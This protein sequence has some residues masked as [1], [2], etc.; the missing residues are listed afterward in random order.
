MQY[1]SSVTITAP[2]SSLILHHSTKS[3]VQILIEVSNRKKVVKGK[4]HSCLSSQA[5]HLFSTFP[6]HMQ[7]CLDVASEKGCWPGWYH[8]PWLLT[9]LPYIREHFAMPCACVMAGLH[10]D[11]PLIVPV[12]LHLRWNT[13]FIVPLED[14]LQSDTMNSEIPQPTYSPKYV[15]MSWLNLL[16]KSFLENINICLTPQQIG[17]IKPELILLP[18]GFGTDIREHSSM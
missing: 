15:V 7:R 14:S 11:F 6:K 10:L 2:L 5:E 13:P 9:V 8:F 18:E 4:R 17:K 1:Q 12:G 16:Y 3:I